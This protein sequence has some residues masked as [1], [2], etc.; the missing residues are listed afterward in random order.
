MQLKGR[1][2][3]AVLISYT[4][5]IFFNNIIIQLA[6]FQRKAKWEEWLRTFWPLIWV[7]WVGLTRKE[8]RQ[9][10]SSYDF[11]ILWLHIISSIKD[12]RFSVCYLTF[13][14]ECSWK[15]TFH[16]TFCHRNWNSSLRFVHHAYMYLWKKKKCQCRIW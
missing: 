14:H 2:L 15:L 12:A 16:E 1:F 9:N 5:A 3:R 11:A 6:E 4:G 10:C 7:R 13:L 8:F